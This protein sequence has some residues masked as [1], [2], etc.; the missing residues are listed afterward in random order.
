MSHPAWGN[1]FSPH[2]VRAGNFASL[3][4][5]ESSEVGSEPVPSHGQ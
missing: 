3:R 5:F 4:A 1:Y 2:P